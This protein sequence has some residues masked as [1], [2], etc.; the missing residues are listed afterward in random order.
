MSAFTQ[1]LTPLEPNMVTLLLNH[2]FSMNSLK[3]FQILKQYTWQS[4]LVLVLLV[5]APIAAKAE[6]QEYNL[7]TDEFYGLNAERVLLVSTPEEADRKVLLTGKCKSRGITDIYLE[8]DP[9]NARETWFVVSENDDNEPD[10][11][12]CLTGNLPAWFEK[13]ALVR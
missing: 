2:Y 7:V 10:L 12:I 8:E 4:I 6:V 3:S 13:V 1:E 11:K 9:I 5:I